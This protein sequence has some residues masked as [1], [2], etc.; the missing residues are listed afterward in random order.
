MADAIEPLVDAIEPLANAIKPLVNAID[1]IVED[2]QKC[3]DSCVSTLT[4]L[5]LP[6]F[7]ITMNPN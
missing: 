7:Q 5:K 3:H 2:I 4:E 1:R 6:I